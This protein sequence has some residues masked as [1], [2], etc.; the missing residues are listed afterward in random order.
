VRKYLDLAELQSEG[1]LQ[2]VNRQ[3]FHPLG[4]ALSILAENRC[5]ECDEEWDPEQ[6]QCA[7]CGNRTWQTHIRELSIWDARED[8]EGIYFDDGVDPAKADNVAS[9]LLE[10][11]P[12]REAALGYIIQPIVRED[13]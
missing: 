1:Y 10:R 7:K 12:A 2:E 11:A 8:M 9:Q 5:E 6:E 13:A 4:L 3:F